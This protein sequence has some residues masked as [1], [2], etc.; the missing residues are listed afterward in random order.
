[1]NACASRKPSRCTPT[2][3]MSNAPGSGWPAFF[4]AATHQAHL[5][6]FYSLSFRLVAIC[7]A[8]HGFRSREVSCDLPRTTDFHQAIAED[9]G[10]FAPWVFAGSKILEILTSPGPG[11]GYDPRGPQRP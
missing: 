10:T 5:Q 7:G 9:L 11:F 4:V 8:K 1:M 6:P 2:N 3:L